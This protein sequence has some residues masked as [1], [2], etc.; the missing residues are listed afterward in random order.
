MWNQ[1][2]LF[3]ETSVRLTFWL[4]TTSDSKWPTSAS[5]VPST[6]PACTRA[7]QVGQTRKALNI[8]ES[9]KQGFGCR[10]YWQ[11]WSGMVTADCMVRLT[12]HRVSA[13]CIVCSNRSSVL[14]SVH[15]SF[16]LSVPSIDSSSKNFIHRDL[17]AA[18]VLVG[19]HN[20]VKVADFGRMTYT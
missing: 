19:D 12:I 10:G 18:N 9:L 3:I 7:D 11:V 15:V 20:T 17:R 6:T 4:I 5:R 13:V 1:P 16:C 14:P 8:M 2:T